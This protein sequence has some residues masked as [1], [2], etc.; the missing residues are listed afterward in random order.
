MVRLKEIIDEKTMLEVPIFKTINDYLEILKKEGEIKLTKI[1]N[2]PPKYVKE[3]YHNNEIKEGLI[4]DG[5]STLRNEL[6]SDGVVVARVIAEICKFTK[7]RKNK[8]SLTMNGKKIMGDRKAFFREVVIAFTN[9]YNW[10]YLDGYDEPL[11]LGEIVSYTYYLINK[12]G[13]TLRDTTFYSEKIILAFPMV[14]LPLK[15]EKNYIQTRE[16]QF[17]NIY[18]LRTFKRYMEFLGIVKFDSE[19]FD[20]KIMKKQLFDKI[21]DLTPINRIKELNFKERKKDGIE[22]LISHLNPNQLSKFNRD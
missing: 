14:L 10:G 16:D 13:N 5:L 18:R 20:G 3:I 21:I 22:D 15:T 1:G 6:D 4:E 19:R 12:Y 7:I 9:K 8:L 2:L 11:R 17:N